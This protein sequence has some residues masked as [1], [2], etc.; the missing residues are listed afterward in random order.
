M[1]LGSHRVRVKRGSLLPGSLL[2]GSPS[3]LSSHQISQGRGRPGAHSI[4]CPGANNPPYLLWAGRQGGW[5][6]VPL[7]QRGDPLGCVSSTPETQLGTGGRSPPA[8]VW[9]GCPEWTGPNCP[10]W[11]QGFGQEGRELLSKYFRQPLSSFWVLVSDLFM[12]SI[13]RVFI[14]SVTI[15]LPFFVLIF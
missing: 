11:L 14:E 2:A 4:T 9:R 3:V 15:L 8:G 7:D 5:C 13:F 10:L 6:D 12:W 1:S